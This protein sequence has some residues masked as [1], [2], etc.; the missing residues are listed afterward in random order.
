MQEAK[1][2]N[3]DSEIVRTLRTTCE[4]LAEPII[5]PFPTQFYRALFGRLFPFE[6]LAL[7][8]L[9]L[10]PSELA[11]LRNYTNCRESGYKFW[12]RPCGDDIAPC[13]RPQSTAGHG[14]CR[15]KLLLATYAFWST[16]QIDP[17]TEH[18]CASCY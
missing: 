16:L 9:N 3:C 15:E 5:N 2:S 12:P 4:P 1:T 14:H 17:D 13:I 6:Q 11:Q 7:Y 8:S 10:G 18:L